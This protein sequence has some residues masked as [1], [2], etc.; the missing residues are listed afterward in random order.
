LNIYPLLKKKL[1]K[2]NQKLNFGSQNHAV[3]KPWIDGDIISLLSKHM[4]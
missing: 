4:T 2:D 1:N 3:D